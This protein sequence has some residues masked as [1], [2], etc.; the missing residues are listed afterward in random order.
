MP[1]QPENRLEQQYAGFYQDWKTTGTQESASVMLQQIDPVINKAITSYASGNKS[2]NVRSH[3]RQIA[4]DALESYDPQKARLQTHLL[5]QLQGLRRHVAQEQQVLS[6]PEQVM[7]D[8]QHLYRS[9]MVLQ[10][11]LGRDPSDREVS[12]HT[13]I[14]LK[15]LAYVRQYRSPLAEGTLEDATQREGGSPAMPAVMQ[16]DPTGWHEFVYNDLNEVDKAI[17]EYTLGLHGIKKLPATEIA[18]KLNISPGAISQR[19]QRIQAKLNQRE[20]L[21]LGL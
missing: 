18:K 7:L 16:N 11:K 15:R 14:S 5:N 20:D 3:A 12:D 17:M 10:D 19:S 1:T 2:P 4:L 9:S 6:V 8:N 21:G 13:G